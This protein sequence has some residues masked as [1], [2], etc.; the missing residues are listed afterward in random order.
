[1][2]D[3]GIVND[4]SA[5]LPGLET[6]EVYA[7]DIARHAHNGRLAACDGDGEGY[8][9]PPVQPRRHR[10]CNNFDRPRGGIR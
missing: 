8:S 10:E 9:V 2:C 6:S 1:M 7:F 4:L 3:I 5:M